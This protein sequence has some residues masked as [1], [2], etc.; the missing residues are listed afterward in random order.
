MM[1]QDQLL[2]RQGNGYNIPFY[3]GMIADFGVLPMPKYTE[4]Q[5]EYRHVVASQYATGLTIPIT[6]TGEALD[7]TCVI[8][9][10]LSAASDDAID[11]YY[12]VNLKSKNA[13][14]EESADMLE[15]IFNSK[16]YDLAKTFDWAKLETKVIVAAVKAPG[17]LASLYE[18]NKAAAETAMAESFEFFK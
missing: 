17:T 11:A 14:D 2:Y 6:I 5:E 12:E 13:R 15:I 16:C 10:A 18:S 9:T 7:R 8:I 1:E 3:R 4:D